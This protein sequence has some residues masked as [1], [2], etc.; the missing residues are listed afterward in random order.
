[1]GLKVRSS[2]RRN[3]VLTSYA[4]GTTLSRAWSRVG[5][6]DFIS[7]IPQS[8]YAA[9]SEVLLQLSQG[10]DCSS[11]VARKTVAWV[12]FHRRIDPGILCTYY[13]ANRY[14]HLESLPQFL[15]SLYFIISA[16]ILPQ[17][18]WFLPPACHPSLPLYSSPK[19]AFN[20]HLFVTPSFT[21]ISLSIVILAVLL[22]L[23]SIIR[24][25]SS[26]LTLCAATFRQ[27][28]GKGR[29]NSVVQTHHVS[30]GNMSLTGIAS[31]QL[32]LW[33]EAIPVSDKTW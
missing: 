19:S 21:V 4:G 23:P 32:I 2:T 33:F 1:M 5:I 15:Q 8:S 3:R 25:S 30:L 24:S 7:D 26:R 17:L 27:G 18:P 28:I 16:R 10:W 22:L 31:N 12:P 20:P 11:S 9:D 13:W 29:S 14:L 6:V